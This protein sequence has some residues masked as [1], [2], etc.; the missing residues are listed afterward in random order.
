[1]KEC[2]SRKV[3]GKILLTE[4]RVSLKIVCIKGLRY[5]ELE[6]SFDVWL[7]QKKEKEK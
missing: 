4:S 2:F 7:S 3:R 5:I 6:H 1:M